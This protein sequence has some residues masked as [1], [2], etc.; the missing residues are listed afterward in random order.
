MLT[1]VS[2]R[3]DTCTRKLN[4]KSINQ[5]RRIP[6]SETMTGE[7]CRI[8]SFLYPVSSRSLRIAAC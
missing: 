5:I 8:D 7:A 4:Q 3:H 2:V 6:G 1:T